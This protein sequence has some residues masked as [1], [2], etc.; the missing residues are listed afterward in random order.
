MN[1]LPDQ[2][3]TT[4]GDTRRRGPWSI[5]VLDRNPDDPMWA[6]AF[7]AIPGDI[8]PASTRQAVTQ[9]GRRSPNGSAGCTRASGSP[10][11][12]CMTRWCG[13]STTATGTG[14]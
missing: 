13:R 4:P 11:R 1:D 10:S 7:I 2:P 12:R 6:L 5:L 14:P 8:R 3:R 9:T